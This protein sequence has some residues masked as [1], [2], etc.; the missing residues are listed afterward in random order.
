MQKPSAFLQRQEQKIAHIR[1]M[2]PDPQ[3]LTQETRR[4]LYE[5][6]KDIIGKT[7][8]RSTDAAYGSKIWITE[9]SEN[10][11]ESHYDRCFYHLLEHM[12][13]DG[14]IIPNQTTLMEVTSGSA[15]I[16]FGWIC[17]ILGYQSKIVIPDEL[18]PARR[19]IIEETVDEVIPSGRP[20]E[21]LE[22]AVQ[23]FKTL[24]K[25]KQTLAEI[26]NKKLALPNHSQT[27]L[28]PRAFEDIGREV[29]AALPAHL[30]LDT[31]VCA[32]GNGTT[33]T[34][35]TRGLR[36][37]YKNISVHGFQDAKRG[38]HVTLFGAGGRGKLPMPFVEPQHYD[39]VTDLEE[40]DW[41]PTFEAYNRG[42]TREDTIGRTS[43]AALTLA[44]R[45]IEQRQ[46][47][48]N[49]LILFYDKA[50]RYGE[51]IVTDERAVYA[52][53]GHWISE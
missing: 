52:G 36:E 10:P 45:I 1:R 41:L 32:I 15:G 23:T 42:K 47:A 53:D 7:P 4:E 17:K 28:T 50:D 8:L 2:F 37:Q 13:S 29:I 11:G 35:I 34:G 18:P 14:S 20:G 44:N 31:F 24:V 27:P 51:E 9:E 46:Q 38:N 43:A 22:G 16:S 12:E 5:A 6:L 33:V 25:N 19:R 3:R 26:K 40:A 39:Q 21:Y 48:M 49:I 30:H